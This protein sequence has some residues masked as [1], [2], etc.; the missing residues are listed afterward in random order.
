MMM[1]LPQ[2]LSVKKLNSIDIK[3]TCTD[4]KSFMVYVESGYITLQKNLES[5]TIR[6]HQLIWDNTCSFSPYHIHL[7]PLSSCWLLSWDKPIKTSLWKVKPPFNMK[8]FATCIHNLS[9]TPSYEH[10]SSIYQ[11]I[12]QLHNS[13]NISFGQEVDNYLQENIN[14]K[15]TTS[16]LSNYLNL[17][18][19][20]LYKK[21]INEF[22]VSPSVYVKQYKMNAATSLIRDSDA[23]V[24]S[25]A[26]QLGFDD[27]FYF[28]RVFKNTYGVSPT[29]YKEQ[30]VHGC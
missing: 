8:P 20:T 11:L 22:G 12:D 26:K 15:L 25:I 10:L 13:K 1:E 17:P 27:E 2:L 19:S 29:L 5:I 30:N 24:K 18:S 14:T 9:E 16:D 23:S 7:S 28:S 6:T 4:C 21:F 3:I